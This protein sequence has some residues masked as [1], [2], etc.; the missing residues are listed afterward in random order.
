M[1]TAGIDIGSVSAEMVILENSTPCRRSIV[2]TGVSSHS[3]VQRLFALLEEDKEITRDAIVRT[4]TTGYGR[5]AA[6]VGDRSVTELSCH[7]RGAWAV[8]H[9]VR[10][11][12]DIGG[13]DSKVIRVGPDGS[14]LDFIMNDK[15]AAGTGRFLEIIAKTLELPLEELGPLALQAGEPVKISSMCAVFAESE[16]V[17]LRAEGHPRDRIVRGIADSIANRISG[18]VH[19]VGLVVPV[20][21]TGGVAKNAGVVE[22]LRDVLGVDIIVPPEPEF[23]G[24][25]GAAY[26]AAEEALKV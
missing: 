14:S 22:A 9:T 20:M 17:S 26:I 15:C 3:A 18:M 25:L 24:A 21:L 11:V 19:R 8:D 16:V 6:G 2:Q 23:I 4:V 1:Y 7:A 12:I 13:Q 5:K 10:T